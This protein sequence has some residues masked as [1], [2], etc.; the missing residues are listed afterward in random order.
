MIKI[1][2]NNFLIFFT[3]VLLLFIGISEAKAQ[4]GV[5]VSPKIIDETAQA[6]DIFNYEVSITNNTERKVELYAVVNEVNADGSRASSTKDLD[7]AISLRKWIKITHPAPC[8]MTPFSAL[9]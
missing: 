7:R 9:L 3:L 1:S 5:V 4:S 8:K 2:N 6:R